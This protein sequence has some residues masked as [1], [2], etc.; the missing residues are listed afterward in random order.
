MFG[1]L[2]V[3]ASN[4]LAA[5]FSICINTS[6]DRR[7]LPARSLWHAFVV[8]V[9]RAREDPEN[10]STKRVLVVTLPLFSF[11]K[12]TYKF[13]EGK[14]SPRF[15]SGHP[16]CFVFLV[17]EEALGR[18]FCH[19]PSKSGDSLIAFVLRLTHRMMAIESIQDCNDW[20]KKEDRC[21]N[22]E[23]RF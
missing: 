12:C 14:H 15:A 3:F 4:L 16:T 19:L 6:R 23:Q 5:Y 2:R 7:G 18:S 1:F 17:D 20:G 21:E 22:D 9:L 13:Q 11:V 10:I 8:Q